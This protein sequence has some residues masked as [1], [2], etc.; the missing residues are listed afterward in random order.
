MLLADALDWESV[1]ERKTSED[2]RAYEWGIS[3]IVAAVELVYQLGHDR[4]ESK[5]E[6]VLSGMKGGLRLWW[7][8]NALKW[9]RFPW[10]R[11]LAA[12]FDVERGERGFGGVGTDARISHLI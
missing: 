7:V 2:Q 10:R 6:R 12:G 8:V 5:G 11:T 4:L 1:C 9:R 3:S